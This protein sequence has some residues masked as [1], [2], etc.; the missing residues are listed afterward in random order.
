MAILQPERNTDG[1]ISFQVNGQ[2]EPNS[3][4]NFDSRYV[5]I[6]GWVACN[7]G[8]YGTVGVTSGYVITGIIM[9]IVM[10][11]LTERTDAQYKTVAIVV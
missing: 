7:M 3:Y 6:S 2:M 9:A 1:G 10:N 11:W 8:G 5:R 4:S